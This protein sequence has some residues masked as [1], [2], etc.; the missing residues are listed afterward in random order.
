MDLCRQWF[1]YG[2]IN[3]PAPEGYDETNKNQPMYDPE[4]KY[5][6]PIKGGIANGYKKEDLIKFWHDIEGYCDYLLIKL[7]T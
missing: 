5:G 3:K 2:K 6:D 4:A 7:A 1:I